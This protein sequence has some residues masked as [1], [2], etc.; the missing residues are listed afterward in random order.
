MWWFIGIMA[1]LFAGFLLFPSH[2]FVSRYCLNLLVAI[3]Q[4]FNTLFLGDP[5]ET[6]SS[7]IGNGSEA[8]IK[9]FKFWAKFLDF[10]DKGHA[11]R[12]IEKDEGGSQITKH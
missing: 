5:D 1:V 3:D 2:T 11:K 9:F 8:G 6:L 12:E 10:F 7:R 4:F